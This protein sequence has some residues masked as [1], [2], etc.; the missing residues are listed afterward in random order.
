MN[1]RIL[2]II[3]AGSAAACTERARPTFTTE[4]GFGV[5]PTV[6][7]TDPAADTT[8]AAGSVMIVGGTVFD[9][10]GI[11]SV[12]FSA[13]GLPSRLSPYAAGGAAHLSFSFPVELEG[14]AGDTIIVSVYGANLQHVRGDLASRRVALR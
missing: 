8:V 3:L 11:D 5:G 13:V 14:E 9:E 7:I 12:F 1:S 4:P 10:E 6:T 2:G